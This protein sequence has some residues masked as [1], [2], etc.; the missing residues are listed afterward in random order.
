MEWGNSLRGGRR[1]GGMMRSVT[2]LARGG[3]GGGHRRGGRAARRYLRAM[4]PTSGALSMGSA[5]LSAAL[6]RYPQFATR[7]V[8]VGA[9]G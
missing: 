5:R 4:P 3:L 1:G 8:G 9:H 2:G 7:V 6:V